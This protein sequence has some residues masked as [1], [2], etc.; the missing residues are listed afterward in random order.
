MTPPSSAIAIGPERAESS[1]YFEKRSLKKGAVNWV[2]LMSLGVAYVISGDFSGWNYGI[3][4]GG[5]MGMAIAF[6]VMGAM[7]LFMVLGI[8]E[9]S[10]AMPTA[11]AGYGFAR[12]AMGR[13]G[14]ALTGFSI[15]IEYTICPAAISTFI[16]AYVHD[17][18][19]FADVPSYAIIGF[20]FIILV[21]IH[22]FGVGE[23]LK[24]ILG[25]TVVAMIALLAFV[26]GMIPHF[27]AANLFDIAPAV[28]DGTTMLP[29]GASGILAALPFGIWLFLAIEGVPLAAEESANPKRDMPRGILAAIGVLIVTGTLVLFLCAGGAGA[30][31]AGAAPAPLVDALNAVGENN[32]AL[33]VNYAGLAG[34]IASFFSTVFSSSRQA[35]ALSRAGYLPKF[36]SVT[37]NRKTPYLALIILGFIGYALAVFVQDGDVLLNMAVFAACVSYAMMNL[38]HILLRKKEPGMERGFKAP[39]GIVLTSI[40]LVLS[41]V[42]IVSTFVVD[43]FAAGCTLLVLAALMV[44]FFLYSSKHLVGNAPEEEFAA[45]EQAAAELR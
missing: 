7:Y 18:G 6:V 38:S 20:F 17:L 16:A 45:M 1:E 30:E 31:F 19:L 40:S 22:I 39:G 3:G 2:L 27:D 25:I 36:L 24:L 33:F 8:A 26:F 32:L 11:G 4:N 5:W 12:R 23:A 14:G 10:S 21:G 41:I 34:L 43:S 28:A 13:I 42:A 29:Y 15:L 44:Y 35:F 9:M 37:G